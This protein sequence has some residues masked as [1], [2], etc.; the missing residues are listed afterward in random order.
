M[1][2]QLSYI[3]LCANSNHFLTRTTRK[4]LK[5]N[6]FTLLNLQRPEQ[7]LKRI[8]YTTVD[9]CMI[10]LTEGTEWADVTSRIRAQHARLPIIH[11]SDKKRIEDLATSVNSGADDFLSAPFTP[12]EIILRIQ[13]IVKRVS[14]RE[15]AEEVI[16]FG[17]Y[18][19]YPRRSVLV[20][21][22]GKINL[23]YFEHRVLEKL[24]EN[25]NCAV[26]KRDIMERV[27]RSVSANSLGVYI[28]R[29]RRYFAKTDINI[30]TVPGLGYKLTVKA[31]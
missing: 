12:A 27:G 1:S 15:I 7:V 11:I 30:E 3:L 4:Q 8:N 26:S 20:G 2:K 5:N 10:G 17:E 28:H 31:G 14:E 21:S 25:R 22:Q 6:G 9:V 16:R 13:R 18:S 19:F 29:L 24:V 23:T